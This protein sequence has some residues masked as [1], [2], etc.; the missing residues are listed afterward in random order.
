ME[1][2]LIYLEKW[3][4]ILLTD[5]DGR[6]TFH[7]DVL[8]VVGLYSRGTVS[9]DVLKRRPSLGRAAVC[10]GAWLWNMKS[11]LLQR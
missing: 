4:D 8:N 9:V 5:T 11:P 2:H 3:T 6:S 7:A 1:L 10:S